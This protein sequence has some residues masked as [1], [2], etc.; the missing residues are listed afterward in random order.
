VLQYE[1]EAEYPAFLQRPRQSLSRIAS[2]DGGEASATD[3][4]IV[5]E[6][7]EL[8]QPQVQAVQT[9]V[10]DEIFNAD[11]DAVRETVHG[12]ARPQLQNLPIVISSDNEAGTIPQKEEEASHISVSA[13]EEF[14]G[15]RKQEGSVGSSH[16]LSK[17]TPHDSLQQPSTKEIALKAKCEELSNQCWKCEKLAKP[18]QDLK[19]CGKCTAI[20]RTI[21]YCSR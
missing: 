9:V 19:L 11:Q 7:S 4:A 14:Q 1:E 18:G 10:E 13:E 21:R 16:D 20:G 6:K 3:R 5:Q 8:A 17:E 12:L 2:G 15:E